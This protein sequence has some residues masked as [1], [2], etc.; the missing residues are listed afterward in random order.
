MFDSKPSTGG[1]PG[2]PYGCPWRSYCCIRYT[3]N[4]CAASAGSGDTKISTAGINTIKVKGKED[5]N[6]LSNTSLASSNIV[7][8]VS[9]VQQRAKR[10]F[11]LSLC[12]QQ[13]TAS[14]S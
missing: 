5:L 14:R 11:Q 1:T 8:I 4:S 7:A 13:L 6:I 3:V 12:A 10:Y 9:I 2:L